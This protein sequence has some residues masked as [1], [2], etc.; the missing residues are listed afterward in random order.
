MCRSKQLQLF[1]SLHDTGRLGY[2]TKALP[3]K[4]L[5]NMGMLAGMHAWQ[6]CRYCSLVRKVAFRQ[7][8]G[9][10][11]K[12]PMVKVIDKVL[13]QLQSVIKGINVNILHR[14]T[15]PLYELGMC[16]FSRLCDVAGRYM[17]DAD[18]LSRLPG[19]CS[20]ATKRLSTD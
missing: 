15:M 17:I 12:G 8:A 13:R 14:I 7:E 3:I 11:L 9:I 2:I 1:K 18:A 4:Q 20:R 19:L 6:E 5:G 16:D 10:T